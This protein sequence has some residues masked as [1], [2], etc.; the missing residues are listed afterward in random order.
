[1]GLL[2]LSALVFLGLAIGESSQGDCPDY[3]GVI[4]FP[5]PDC[6][7]FW[8]GANGQAYQKTC[9]SGLYFNA[10][11][12]VCDYPE[13]TNC[14]SQCREE[15]PPCPCDSEPQ[16]PGTEKPSPSPSTPSASTTQAPTP[17][18]SPDRGDS[19]DAL[20][21]QCPAVD[22]QHP[23]YIPLDDCSKFCQCSNG[24]AYQHNCPA[25]LHFNPVL[26]VCD[27]PENANCSGASGTTVPAPSPSSTTSAPAA[28]SSQSPDGD[29]CYGLSSQCPAVD[30]PESVYI[31]LADC[32]KFCQ[33]SNGVAYQHNCPANL[34]FNP[35]LNVCD[36]P[37]NANCSGA[38][39]TTVP[40]PSPSSTTSAP[41]TSSSQSPDG[42]SCYGLSSQC[43]AVDGPNS[44]Y[45]PL[46][47]CTK[48]CQCSNGVAYQHN[49]PANLHFN[50]V[51]NVCDYPENANCSGASGTT[52]PAPSPSSTT[53][54]PAPSSSQSPD[55]DSCY[56]LSSQC[57]AVDGPD[58]VYIPLADCTKFCQCSNGVA[59]QHNC[60]A[61]L[62]FNPVLNVC[63]YPENA[64][65][66]GAS[67][68]T[69]P[70]PSPSSTTSAPATSSSQSPDG[71][72]CYGLSSQCPAVDGPD[73]VYI[74]LADCTK[75]CQCS[76]GVAYQHNCPANLH[77]N[78]VLNVCDYPENANCSGASGTTV[79]TP[80]PS[81]TT[82][83]PAPSSSQSP[84][85]DS[86]YGLSSQC[87]AVDGPDSVYIPL[88]DCTKFCQC[89]NGVAY[90]HNCPA[91][92]HFNPV[93]NVCDYPENANCSGVSGTTVPTPAPSSSSEA[94]A[95][96]SSQSPKEDSCGELSS[97]CP[98]EDGQ[99][100]VYIPL[101]DCTKFCQCSNGRAYQHDCQ[102][103]QHF[104]PVKNVCDYPEDA[105]CTGVSGTTVSTS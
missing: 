9:P 41:A 42:D 98:A 14:V 52:V 46:A 19:C 5:D 27:Y 100:P 40:A 39:G 104:N 12:E 99:Y 70:A 105:G 66:S 47:D 73:S 1:M 53:S 32:T 4:Y 74:P 8:Y 35:V 11:L 63:D 84:D 37:E 83:A 20:S 23:V 59:Y 69:V 79:P 87:P 82:S 25:N 22:G 31:P 68:T 13:N 38:S 94:P 103:N 7:K 96:S 45:I 17:S 24:V 102:P 88:A 75:F 71:D 44:V 62:H 26:N 34:H 43:P 15:E 51:L 60:P 57:P 2:L 30:G 3:N 21:S 28:S 49:C 67:G 76:N 36:Y 61:N 81:S 85:G 6:T 101:A 64:N 80:S 89:S 90:Q 93:L 16:C 91:N 78:P 29:S 95:P 97:Q 77:F 58:S 10:K 72:S 54:A 50:P 18:T 56:G 65:C 86:C 92:L 48:F 33:C 55:G